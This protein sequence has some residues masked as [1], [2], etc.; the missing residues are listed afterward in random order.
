M[1]RALENLIFEANG[2]FPGGFIVAQY[3]QQIPGPGLRPVELLAQYLV[4]EIY[5]LYNLTSDDYANLSRLIAKLEI[6][7]ASLNEV[8]HCFREL[9]A[10]TLGIDTERPLG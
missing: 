7:V 9:R 6:T 5:E 3:R 1:A 4:A 2:A 10:A 8:A